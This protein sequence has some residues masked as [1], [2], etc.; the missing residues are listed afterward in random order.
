MDKDLNKI[1]PELFGKIRTQFPKIKLGDANGKVTDRAEDARFFE[2]DFVKHGANLGTISV[3]LSEDDGLV[4][5]YTNDVVDGQPNSVKKQWYNFLEQLREFAGQR[6]LDWSPRNI[7]KSNLDKRDY[8]FLAKHNGEGS[9]TES[10]LWGTSKTSY[11][12]MGEAKIIVRH[13]QPVNYNHAAGRTLH[14]ESIYVENADGERFKY[15][16]KHLNGARAL[17][18]HVAHGGNS[19]DPMGQHIIGLSEELN[20]LRMFKNYVDRNPMVSEAVGQIQT[21]VYERIAQVKK[22]IHS[23]QNHN[24]YESFAE[25]FTVNDAQEIPE[26]LVNDWVDRLTIR[27]FNEE[28][29]NVFPYIYKL[30]GEEIDVVKELTADD[31]LDEE[32]MPWETDDE[33]K[34]REAGKKEKS[35]FKKPH[36]PNRTPHDTVK[37]LARK[38]MPKSE[39]IEPVS[40]F[41]QYIND[42]LAE[43]DDLTSSDQ[44]V[45]DAA[46]DK[47][48]QLLAQQQKVGT[49][50]AN[51]LMSLKGLIDDPE[52]EEMLKNAPA[53]TDLNT[54]VQGWV[55]TNHPDLADKLKFDG[56]AEPAPEP[57]PEA[58]PPAPA[59]EATPPAPV[60]EEY[61]E[62]DMTE[63]NEIVEFIRSM[64]DENTGQFP[65]GETGVILACE[66]EFGEEAGQVA[67][68]V[69]GELSAIYESHRMRQLAGLAKGGLG[70]S[71]LSADAAFAKLYEQMSMPGMPDM[72][73]MMKNIGGMPGATKSSNFKS[74]I[75]GKQDDS[76]AGYNSAMGK[77]R[78]MAGGMGLDGSSIDS[79]HK[80]IQGKVGDMMKGMNMPGMPGA[81]VQAPAKQDPTAMLKSLPDAKLSTMSG[82]EAK[83]M[84]ADLKKMAGMKE[85]ST[86][87]DES[88]K[89]RDPKYKDKLYTQNPDDDDDHY[90]Y[91]HD[92]RPDN[93]PGQKH[94]TFDRSN[95][96]DKLHYH[97]GDHQVGQKAKIGDRAKKGLL[98]KTS[99]GVVKDRIKN[100]HGKHPTPNLPENSELAAM[101]KI[102]GVK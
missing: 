101:L 70:E 20:K 35:P 3:S 46:V 42:I 10:K 53:E 15:P 7:T 44:E 87:T 58:T 45:Q 74:T 8:K 94:S 18:T 100:V 40:A 97:Y 80:G 43:E 30:V 76:E 95:D 68:E 49:D 9:M 25:S 82:D 11:Q 13:T 48:N 77:F 32:T 27:T 47:L 26:D 98:T 93:D 72:D 6:M 14:I 88:A 71:N 39:T 31:L 2:F 33:A 57:A 54:L 19:Y 17:A 86:E 52:F 5:L 66:K 79:M 83:S 91:Y 55:E 92:S 61:E 59:P 22:E 63:S 75:N 37:A 29:K 4:C 36:N 21:K 34:E 69:I 102:A 60:A 64:Y 67:Q 96:K 1:A 16:F 56:S 12:D 23:L 51:A 62:E 85:E 99:M 41:E 81:P 73:S 24:Y 89:W 84:L 38:G 90:D 28:L 78:D 50:G 65:K